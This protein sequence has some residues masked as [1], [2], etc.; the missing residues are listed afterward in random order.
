MIKIKLLCIFR[1]D[2]NRSSNAL[3]LR[4]GS[5]GV[6]CFLTR[7]K[8]TKSATDSQR[9]VAAA[10]PV[11]AMFAD[12]LEWCALMFHKIGFYVLRRYVV[13]RNAGG[14]TSTEVSRCVFIYKSIC[15]WIYYFA[16][17]IGRYFKKAANSQMINILVFDKRK[18]SVLFAQHPM[19]FWWAR[20]VCSAAKGLKEAKNGLEQTVPLFSSFWSVISSNDKDIY[21]FVFTSFKHIAAV[22]LKRQMNVRQFFLLSP[23]TFWPF[24]SVF[25]TNV[26]QMIYKTKSA[27]NCQI[28]YARTW[29]NLP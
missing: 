17:E 4:G 7:T 19:I 1:F 20:N 5:G 9:M 18:S 12:V 14:L 23:L 10:A 28:S 25:Q 26:R 8:E 16:A 2:N 15:L 3:D 29:L 21:G 6:F 24:C 27:M 22:I 11:M 13:M